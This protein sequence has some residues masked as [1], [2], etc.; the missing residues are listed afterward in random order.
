MDIDTLK[1]ELT[2]DPLAIGYS[3]MSDE[4]AAASLNTASR[5]VNVE[6]VTGQEIFEAVVLADYAA[7]ELI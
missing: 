6:S 7:R 2:D 5:E 4:E 1:T 3:G